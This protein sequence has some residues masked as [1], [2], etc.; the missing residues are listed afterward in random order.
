M[1]YTEQIVGTDKKYKRS[2][3]LEV[4]SSLCGYVAREAEGR[5]SF[6]LQLLNTATNCIETIFPPL[7]KDT[8]PSFARD[9]KS[10]EMQAFAVNDVMCTL[11]SY[12]KYMETYLETAFLDDCAKVL[13][14]ATEWGYEIRQNMR[15]HMT[16]QEVH[17]HMA[18]FYAEMNST[19]ILSL[20]EEAPTKIVDLSR[21]RTRRQAPEC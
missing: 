6:A 14:W 15:S 2:D 7:T 8:P 19:T 13:A 11:G 16:P 21:R 5:N 4:L 18:R 9:K 3:V 17:D 12:R 1:T 10:A 20:V